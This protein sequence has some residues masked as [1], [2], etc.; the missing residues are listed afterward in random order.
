V[1]ASREPFTL[2][3]TVVK[4]HH[5]DALIVGQWRSAKNVLRAVTVHESTTMHERKDRHWRL[6]L[7]ISTWLP[8]VDE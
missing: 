1:A 8:D 3:E 5:K 4:G 2:T 7:S 6:A